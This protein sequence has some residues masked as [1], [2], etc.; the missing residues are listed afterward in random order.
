MVGGQLCA[1]VRAVAVGGRTCRSYGVAVGVLLGGCMRLAG[2]SCFAHV[3]LR[4]AGGSLELG[5]P[6]RGTR[7]GG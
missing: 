4:L 2:K 7:S 5:S 6:L 3:V 1:F